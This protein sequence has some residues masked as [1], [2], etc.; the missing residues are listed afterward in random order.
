VIRL[1]F[2]DLSEEERGLGVLLLLVA[3]GACLE[4]GF[5][6]C[7]GVVIGGAEQQDRFIEL[8]STAGHVSAEECGVSFPCGEVLQPVSGGGGRFPVFFQYGSSTGPVQLGWCLCG[9]QE[10]GEEADTGDGGEQQQAFFCGEFH[11]SGVSERRR[12]GR[13]ELC[14][15]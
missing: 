7:G 6:A 13:S 3:D 8:S 14:G 2:E 12:G 10:C 9:Q 1:P 11:V 15:N 5:G 4:V